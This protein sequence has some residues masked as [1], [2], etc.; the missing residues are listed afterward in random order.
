MSSQEGR[1]VSSEF[2]KAAGTVKDLQRDLEVV[3]EDLTRL[4]Q[5]VGSIVSAGGNDAIGE[6]KAQLNRI[7]DGVENAISS[8]G[9]K[10]IDAVKDTTDSMLDALEASVRN[11]PIAT[12]GIALGLGFLFG[13]IW[14]R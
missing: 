3:R 8:A 14:R 11:R 9:G 5:Q 10:S 12:L 6:L 4:A 7:R 2:Q 1:A 13:A